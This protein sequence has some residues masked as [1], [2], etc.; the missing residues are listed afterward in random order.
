MDIT[1]KDSDI[2]GIRKNVARYAKL[3]IKIHFTETDVR[4]NKKGGH[5]KLCQ[6][7]NPWPQ[8]HLEKQAE[9]YSKILQICLDEPLCE[10]FETWGFTDRSTFLPDG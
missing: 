1:F 5:R 2:E 10:N 3:G 9:I 7:S 4:C 6:Y 8:E